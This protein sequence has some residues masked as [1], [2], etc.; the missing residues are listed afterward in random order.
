MINLLKKQ[1]KNVLQLIVLF[2]NPLSVNLTKWS[3]TFKQIVGNLPTNCLNVFDHFVGLAL[4]GFTLLMHNV[5]KW[6]K[7]TWIYSNLKKPLKTNQI[8]IHI[9]IAVFK[10]FR[11]TFSGKPVALDLVRQI[12]VQKPI[13]T[14]AKNRKSTTTTWEK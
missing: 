10:M 5:E 1:L 12:Q 4:K 2:L 6:Q 7:H 9:S 3:K 11:K 13:L 8:F 14:P